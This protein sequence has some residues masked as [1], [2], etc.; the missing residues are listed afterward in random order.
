MSRASS[1]LKKGKE[2]EYLA[3]EARKYKSAEE[4]VKSQFETDYFYVNV[5]GRKVEVIKNPS[6]S[7][8]QSIAREM[9]AE[10]PNMLRGEP[11]TRSVYDSKGSTYIWRADKAMHAY[12]EPAIRKKFNVDTDQSTGPGDVFNKNTH[13]KR[14]TDFYNEVRNV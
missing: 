1:I 13:I 11:K 2:F 4:F 3:K 14:L 6:S 10:Y 12:I 9:R 5:S 7:D 8:Y